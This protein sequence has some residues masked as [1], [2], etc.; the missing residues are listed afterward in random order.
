MKLNYTEPTDKKDIK[1]S[2]YLEVQQLI[3]DEAEDDIIVAKVIG[4]EHHYLKHFPKLELDSITANV[5]RVLTEETPMQQTFNL[6]G[7]PYGFIPNLE[8]ITVGEFADLENLF[9]D[10]IKN[11]LQLMNVMYRPITERRKDTYL[12]ESYNTDTD[13]NVFK[14]VPCSIYDSAV[15]FFLSLKEQLQNATRKSTVE[16]EVDKVLGKV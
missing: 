1:L 2:T 12:I 14:D 15:G 7:K 6:N 3:I 11:A 9:S 16:V 4:V 5:L 8:K 10:P 13:I